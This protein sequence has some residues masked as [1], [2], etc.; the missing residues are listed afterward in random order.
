MHIVYVVA[1]RGIPVYGSKGASVHV[2]QIVNALHKLG[3]QVTV[4]AASRGD[5]APCLPV[6]VQ[7]VRSDDHVANDG[8]SRDR[9][10]QARERRAMRDAEC[11]AGHIQRLG[12]ATRVDLVYERFCLFSRAGL[13]AARTLG[14]PLVVELNSPLR[15][16]QR[17]YRDLIHEA[18][19]AAVEHDVL[20]GAD[21][22]IAVSEP[23]ADYARGC[24]AAA[25]RVVVLPNAVDPEQFS[26]EVPRI[27]LPHAA[28]RTVI[29]F[30]GSLKPWHGIDNLM[31]AFR[32]LL[33]HDAGFHLLIAGTGPL[34]T[35]V[36]GFV[37]GAGLEDHVTT[38]GWCPN[39]ELPAVL[40]AA[41][42]LV[43][44]Y[45]PLD[46]F[47][48]SPLKLFE[49]LAMGRAVVASD[50]G[51]ISA[52]LRHRENGLLVPPGDRQAL[53][54]TLRDLGEDPPLRLSLSRGAR[55][56]AL[57]NTWQ[58]TAAAA[59]DGLHAVGRR[60]A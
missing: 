28:N 46:D 39:H 16:E 47:Y 42:I 9:R 60:I 58:H 41:D 55:E 7:Q 50:V 56:T 51:Q 53:A 48:F 24:G 26:P 19:A 33:A 31:H 36:N 23:V 29:G 44:P 22:V 27:E 17:E 21:R 57:R 34:E 14:V 54:R 43:A 59:I 45:P 25:A 3:H 52:V 4:V 37:A 20:A 8:E 6:P 40:A 38:L 18:E 13:T 15:L 12:S 5:E 10:V 49:Y 2:Q 11:I 30:S 32:E 35:W 1:D